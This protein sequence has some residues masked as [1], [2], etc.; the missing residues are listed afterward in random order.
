MFDIPDPKVEGMAGRKTNSPSPMDGPCLR[1]VAEEEKD[2]EYLLKQFQAELGDAYLITIFRNMSPTPFQFPMCRPRWYAI[3]VL[4]TTTRDTIWE[5]S[6]MATRQTPDADT[7]MFADFMKARMLEVK[8][9]C[10]EDMPTW[11]GSYMSFL[12]LAQPDAQE[13]PWE[14]LHELPTLD[15][16]NKVK[17]CACTCGLDPLAVCEV[18]PCKRGCSKDKTKICSW[19]KHHLQHLERMPWW[20]DEIGKIT[21]VELMEANG[22]DQGSSPR[23]RNML[24]ILSYSAKPLETTLLVMDKTQSIGRCGMRNDGFIPTVATKAATCQI[25][26]DWWLIHIKPKVDQ[27]QI[28]HIVLSQVFRCRFT[29]DSPTQVAWYKSL[30]CSWGDSC[31]ARRTCTYCLWAVV[32]LRTSSSLLV[33]RHRQLRRTHGE[34]GKGNLDS[35]ISQNLSKCPIVCVFWS[36]H[37][38]N[39]ITCVLLC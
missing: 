19:R 24:N 17:A 25:I 28:H 7:Q 8:T 16:I 39:Q 37:T 23:E 9:R 10:Q 34:Q 6:P 27:I 35:L 36:A 38:S 4:R 13:I 33:G 12:G 20:K 11:T 30:L 31:D 3:G 26:Q 32:S 14:R 18:H 5:M 21:Y 15:E 1:P 22:L 29:S 2:L